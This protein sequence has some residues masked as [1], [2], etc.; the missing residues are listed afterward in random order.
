MSSLQCTPV[1]PSNRFSTFPLLFPH[2]SFIPSYSLIF[3]KYKLLSFLCLHPSFSL[4]HNLV[5]V[6]IKSQFTVS[7]FTYTSLP[8]FFCTVHSPLTTLQLLNS[9]CLSLFARFITYFHSSF[10][11]SSLLFSRLHNPASPLFPAFKSHFLMHFQ[12]FFSPLLPLFTRFITYPMSVFTLLSLIL[13][14][15]LTLSLP[16]S[17]RWNLDP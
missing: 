13:F 1:K 16:F 2:P 7:V 8:S 17:L 4:L 12:D 10:T 11:L 5:S 9:R 14:F 3:T 15:S 6:S